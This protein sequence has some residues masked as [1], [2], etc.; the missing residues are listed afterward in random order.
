M[1]T[2][3][4]GFCN[5]YLSSD[6]AAFIYDALYHPDINF[7]NGNGN[8]VNN[9]FDALKKKLLYDFEEHMW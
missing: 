3:S 2:I 7:Q 1:V 6:Y 5:V 8:D 4:A 9:F